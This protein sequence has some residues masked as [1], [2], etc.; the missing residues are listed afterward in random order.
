MTAPRSAK[1]EAD[2]FPH[3]RKFV[4]PETYDA[5]FAIVQRLEA[6]IDAETAALAT[7]K[8]HDI[9][10]FT[11]QKRQGF[12][13]LARIMRSMEKTIPSQDILSRLSQF[14]RRLEANESIL[15][16]YLQAVQD[17]TAIIVRVMRDSES[18][19]TYSI[20][21]GQADHYHA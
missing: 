20:A 16:L 19:G 14:R 6:S 15:N 17:V 12:L 9:V 10:R 7:H 18:D 13:E 8:H 21:Y 4:S 1:M 3:D 5:F 11:H 2:F